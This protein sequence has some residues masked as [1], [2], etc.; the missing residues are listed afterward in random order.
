MATSVGE[1]YANK[2][3]K[4]DRHRAVN[5]KG[6]AADKSWSQTPFRPLNCQ[7]I[8]KKG[9]AC[10]AKP[11]KTGHLCSGHLRQAEAILSE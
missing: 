4:L 7:G 6:I 8:T 2:G 10:P 11:V 1:Y 9:T 5:H 3:A